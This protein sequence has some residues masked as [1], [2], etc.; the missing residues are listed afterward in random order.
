MSAPRCERALWS[1]PPV[2]S[3]EAFD[4]VVRTGAGLLPAAP[5]H[6]QE[7]ARILL[8]NPQVAELVCPTCL[9]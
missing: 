8:A 1:L 9:L 2:L 5:W 6:T 3:F 7:N 4:A